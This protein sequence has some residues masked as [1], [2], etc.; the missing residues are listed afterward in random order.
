[1]TVGARR[2][3]LGWLLVAA[4]SLGPIVFWLTAIPLRVRFENPAATLHSLAN[5]AA[6]VGTAG[7]AINLILGARLVV[8]ERLFGGLDR[9]YRAH[10][11]VGYGSLILILLHALLLALSKAVESG[12]GSALE[13]FLPGAGWAIFTGVIALFGMTMAM[14]L[15]LLARLKHETFVYVQRSFG[16]MFLIASFHVFR[17]EGTKAYSHALTVYMGALSALAIAAFFYRSVLGRYLVK[18]R[19]YRVT[20]VNRLDDSV[21]EIV[22][23]PRARPIPFESGQFVFVSVIHGAVG[24]EPHPFS[25]ASSPTDPNLRIVVKALGDY[26]TDLV[27]HLEPPASARV[28]GPYGRFSYGQAANPDQIWIAGGIGVTPFLSMARSLDVDGHRVDFYYCTEGADQAYFL[29]EFFEISDR[30]LNFRVIPIRK[31]SLGHLTVEDIR[32]VSS[33]LPTKDFFICGPPVM[34]RGLKT[35]LLGLGVPTGQIHYEDFGFM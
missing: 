31:V 30:R 4:L 7:F 18:T 19:D 8:V 23:A 28:E 13:L 10:R 12:G 14:V 1:V 11:F 16:L 22:L 33:E 29:D 35:Q 15:T 32:G 24:T 26:T 21:A 5:I 17:V 20:E 6:L 34:I 9:L 2:Q 3:D 25:I 27:E